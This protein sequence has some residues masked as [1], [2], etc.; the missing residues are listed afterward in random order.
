LGICR[1]K[2]HKRA[3][4]GAMRVSIRKKRKHELGRQPA[5]TKIG[6]RRVHTVRVRGGNEKQRALRL[7]VGN[8]AWGSENATKKVRIIRVVYNPTNN[9][10]VR[11]NTLVKGC[12]VEID[13]TPFRQW[14]E[15]RYAVALGRKANFK[16]HEGEED[17]LTKARGKKVSHLM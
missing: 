5:M 8:F 17:P 9:E 6:A 2:R 11:T 13:A 15:N 16:M 12:I 3:P 14:Y 7:D 10:L 4:S 1:D